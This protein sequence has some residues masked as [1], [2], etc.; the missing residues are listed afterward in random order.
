MPTLE[1]LQNEVLTLRTAQTT[2]T[3]ERDALKNENARL[4]K[5]ND[6]LIRHNSKLFAQIPRGKAEEDEEEA[7]KKKQ[8]PVKIDINKLTDDLA[9]GVN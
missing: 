7:K 1:E 4:Q 3:A 8:Q 2:L 6:A 5:E 9:K